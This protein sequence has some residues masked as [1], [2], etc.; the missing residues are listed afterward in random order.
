VNIR[1]ELLLLMNETM[2][3]CMRQNSFTKQ[4]NYET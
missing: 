4:H 2:K 3:K 1:F